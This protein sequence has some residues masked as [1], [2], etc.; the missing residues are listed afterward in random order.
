MHGDVVSHLNISRVQV[1]DGGQYECM[2]ENRAG[3]VVHGARLNVY[4]A[5]VTALIRIV[6]SSTRTT[7][8]GH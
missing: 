3:K 8:Y 2:A 7:V 6:C 5:W 4:G 1:E